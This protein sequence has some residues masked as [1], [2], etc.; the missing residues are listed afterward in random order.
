MLLQP[1]EENIRALEKYFLHLKI[2]LEL[3]V[4]DTGNLVIYPQPVSMARWVLCLPALAMCIRPSRQP[5]AGDSRRLCVHEAQGTQHSARVPHDWPH[6]ASGTRSFQETRWV[7]QASCHCHSLS[8][9][10]FSELSSRPEAGFLQTQQVG[11]R[12]S[13]QQN[14]VKTRLRGW[15]AVRGADQWSQHLQVGC[16][17]CSLRGHMASL[18]CPVHAFPH[19]LWSW[20]HLFFWK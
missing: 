10:S 15:W 1:E 16:L 4:V 7:H 18:L 8:S 2:I 19:L 14:L 5:A 13:F 12:A 6:A 9:S 11:Q 3:F 20:S 17:S